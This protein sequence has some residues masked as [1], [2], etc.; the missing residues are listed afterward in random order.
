MREERG[1]IAGDIVVN[2]ALTLWGSVGGNITVGEKGKLYLRGAAYGD[3]IVEFGGR[4]HIFGRVAG[5]LIVKRGAKVIHSGV[6]WGNATNEG[7]RLFIEKTST[8]NGKVKTIK[9]ETEISKLFGGKIPTKR[10]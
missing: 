2:E 8:I 1:Q 3:I 6:L 4:L 7:G 10:D 5:N 9:G